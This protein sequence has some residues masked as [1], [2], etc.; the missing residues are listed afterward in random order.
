MPLHVSSTF[1]S[2][3]YNS[4]AILCNQLKR[5][6]FNVDQYE[7]AS[8]TE[9]HLLL[10]KNELNM[11]VKH[12]KTGRKCY[13]NYYI[14][15]TLKKNK[16]EEDIENLFETEKLLNKDDGDE[17]LYVTHDDPND[18]LKKYLEENYHQTKIFIIV[19]NFHRL[20]Y[21]VL[22]HNMVP[23]HTVLSEEEKNE[24]YKKYNIMNDKQIAEISRFDPVALSIG[25][26]PGEI[27]EIERKSTTAIS[28]YYYRI[29]V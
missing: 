9:I 6:G 22:D 24:I 18:V 1:V 16:I 19:Y 11:I 5:R 25:I 29:C 3:I 14:D 26:R 13:V 20:L 7:N 27:C 2:D 15:K 12:D 17:I 10:K 28:S 21:N 8:I 23:K 4:R